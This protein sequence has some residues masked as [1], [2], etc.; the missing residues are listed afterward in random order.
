MASLLANIFYVPKSF[1]RRGTCIVG[2]LQSIL[3]FTIMI[4]SGVYS[5]NPHELVELS[6]GTVSEETLQALSGVLII[7]CLG[8]ALMVVLSILIIFGAQTQQP[9]L[10]LPWIYYYGIILTFYMLGIF[11]QVF[12]LVMLNAFAVGCVTLLGGLIT[13]YIGLYMCTI[14]YSHYSDLKKLNF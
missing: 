9:I 8:S 1:R 6:D 13:L 12:S 11:T 4:L 2:A 7:V 5:Q 14:V 10:L 3:S